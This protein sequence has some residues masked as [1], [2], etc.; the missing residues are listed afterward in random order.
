LKPV[1]ERTGIGVEELVPK[2]I[3]YNGLERYLEMRTA[4]IQA[5]EKYEFRPQVVNATLFRAEDLGQAVLIPELGRAFAQAARTPDYGWGQL[6]LGALKILSL[7]CT[8]DSILAEPYVQQVA[9]ELTAF[10]EPAQ[11]ATLLARA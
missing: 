8:H 3:G 4:R 5:L 10:G 9:R 1:A 7:P 6:C 2:D 11:A